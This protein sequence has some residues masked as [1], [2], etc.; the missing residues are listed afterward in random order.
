MAEDRAVS[1]DELLVTHLCTES[2][3]ALEPW[4]WRLV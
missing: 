3:S 4:N 2:S 1:K